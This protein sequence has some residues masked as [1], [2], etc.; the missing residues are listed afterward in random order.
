MLPGVAFGFDDLEPGVGV[1][2]PG[3]PGGRSGTTAD[4]LRAPTGARL[5]FSSYCATAGE[6][7]G[8]G[9]RRPWPRAWPGRRARAAAIGLGVAGRQLDALEARA[10]GVEDRPA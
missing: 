8:R 7:V 5:N 2:D 4:D 3:R 6:P 10:E 1:V 9:G